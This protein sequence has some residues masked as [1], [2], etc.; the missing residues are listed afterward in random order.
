[1]INLKQIN[2]LNIYKDRSYICSLLCRESYSYYSKLKQCFNIPLIV[3]NSAMTII[4]SL[5]YLHNDFKILN[6]IINTLT[7]FILTLINNYNINNKEISFKQGYIKFS[8]LTH[9]IENIL[10]NEEDI[11]NDI[12][13]SIITQYETITDNIEFSYPSFISNKIK[14]KYKDKRNL[15]NC[16]NISSSFFK[17]IDSPISTKLDK[18][19]T[20]KIPHL[21]NDDINISYNV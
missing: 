11:T 19:K 6:I 12:L 16:I 3:L 5:D 1:M 2:L 14:N 4:N 9:F 7:A 10:T 8:K 17:N 13:K 15:P 20:F 18:V 21:S